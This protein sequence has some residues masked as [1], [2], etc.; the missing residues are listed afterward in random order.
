MRFEAK[1]IVVKHNGFECPIIFDPLIMHK[2][3]RGTREVVS[4]GFVII[5]LDR[6]LEPNVVAQCYGRS[7]SLN[8]ESRPEVDSKL[9]GK[10][11]LLNHL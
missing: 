5:T 2:D 4:A 3:M 6:E 1:Y 11:I 8:I 10:K 9:I 7:D